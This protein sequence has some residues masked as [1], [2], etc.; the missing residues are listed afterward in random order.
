[1][2]DLKIIILK[3]KLNSKIGNFIDFYFQEKL[4]YI[5]RKYILLMQ[6]KY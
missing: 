5:L 6:S 4:E 3:L 2:T 1:M